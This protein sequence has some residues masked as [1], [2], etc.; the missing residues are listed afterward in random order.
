[1]EGFGIKNFRS[2]DSEGVFLDKIE[3][4]NIIIGKNNSGK[5]NVL[6][7]F[8]FVNSNINSL[9]NFPNDLTNQHRR[10]GRN[11]IISMNIKGD[12]FIQNQEIL[13][14]KLR[15]Q[16]KSFLENYHMIDYDFIL[17]SI[18]IP[19][20]ITNLEDEQLYPLQNHY[21]RASKADLL[22][23]IRD[24]WIQIINQLIRSTFK[25][26]IYIPHFR[27]IK[28]GHP[29]GD[30]NSSINGSN[31][32]SKMF[33]MQNPKIGQEHSREKFNLIQDF[34][35]DLINKQDLIID[36]PYDK[37]E[38]VLTIDHNRLPL[39]SFGTGIHQLVM[40]CT[41]LVIH[42]NSIV[43]IE[44]PEIHLHPELQR[45]F[46]NFLNK[47][48]NTYFITTHSN[49]FLDSKE[50]TSIYFVQ[51]DGVKST[52]INVNQTSKSFSVLNDLGYK[53]S[54]ILQSNGIIWVEGPSDRTFLLK[55]ISLLDDT[56]VEG[57]HFSIMFYGGRLLSHL[58]FTNCEIIN[59]LVPILKLNRNAY[60]IM[61]RD[62]FTAKK[63]INQTK[64][65]IKEEIGDCNTWITKGREI[66]NYLSEKTLIDW[67]NVKCVKIDSDSKLETIVSQV[68]KIKYETSKSKYSAEI[69]N[70]IGKDDLKVLDLES[71]IKE[72]VTVIKGWNNLI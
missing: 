5:S 66:E 69:I 72:I 42:E 32:I 37:K 41:I 62:G 27:A 18:T 31:I 21:S 33:E 43:C 30:S 4:I 6:R 38:I 3:K 60:V 46:I 28:E 34:I 19:D 12:K 24:N 54:D 9:S 45:K 63:Q 8:Q 7:F 11:A 20:E 16:Y 13:K 65:R 29:F 25:D 57:L 10:N 2:F 36:I 14:S 67:L 39:D 52:L 58:S 70:F 22:Q 26:L 1:M 61:D 49:I 48:K 40:L 56:L 68:S 51:N 59:E 17:N 55:W 35:R 50:N 47:T 64:T 15:Y 44:E 71:K 53:S 23:V